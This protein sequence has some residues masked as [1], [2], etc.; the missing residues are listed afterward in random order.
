VTRAIA[1]KTVVTPDPSVNGDEL[2]VTELLAD[3]LALAT[4]GAV[5]ADAEVQPASAGTSSARTT[6]PARQANRD[7]GSVLTCDPPP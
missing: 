6:R 3:E 2:A 1:L 4:V 5:E 7:Q